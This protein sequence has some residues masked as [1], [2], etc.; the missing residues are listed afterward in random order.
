[1]VKPEP[2][3]KDKKSEIPRES[4]SPPQFSGG[5]CGCRGTQHQPGC[6]RL[7]GGATHVRLPRNNL[8]PQLKSDPDFLTLHILRPIIP[9]IQALNNRF[10]NRQN[11][12]IAGMGP[13]RNI[14]NI[15]NVLWPRV[16]SSFQL[17]FMFSDS[18]FQDLFYFSRQQVFQFRNSQVYPMLQQRAAQG[19]RGARS[20][21]PHTL[22]PDSL[23][24]LF[25]GKVRLNQTGRV[26]GAQLG[27]EHGVVQ[28]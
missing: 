4:M 7:R 19:V 17:P 5:D 8:A 14:T 1:M 6:L 20:Y 21:L 26:L 16:V 11:R 12:W 22:T 10:T 25:L 13:P 23:S 9:V 24:C 15:Q 2:A 27:V 3:N 28:K 18:E